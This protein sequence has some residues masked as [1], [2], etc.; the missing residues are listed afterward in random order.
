M[1]LNVGDKVKVKSL[2]ELKKCCRAIDDDDG[3]LN[4]GYEWFVKEMFDFCGTTATVSRV[5][6][7]AVR[8]VSDVKDLSTYNFTE[9]MLNVIEK[10]TKEK[11]KDRVEIN[12]CDIFEKTTEKIEKEKADTPQYMLI[13]QYTELVKIT[14]SQY[15]LIEFLKSCGYLTDVVIID[16]NNAIDLT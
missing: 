1:N 11:K 14:P 7:N 12:P 6:T 9:D 15:E 4:F 13:N 2:E 16:T 8:L 5:F 10:N 3:E